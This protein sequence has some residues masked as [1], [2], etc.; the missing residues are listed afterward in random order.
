[1]ICWLVKHLAVTEE[2]GRVRHREEEVSIAGLALKFSGFDSEAR[3]VDSRP[4]RWHRAAQ[5]T[6][7]QAIRSADPQVAVVT[8]GA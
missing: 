4:L 1:M 5:S 8:T 3:G 6:V 2:E 7:E